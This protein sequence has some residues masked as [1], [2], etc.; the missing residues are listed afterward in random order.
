MMKKQNL[1]LLVA[2]FTISNGLLGLVEQGDRDIVRVCTYNI[3]RGAKEKEA[4]NLWENRKGLVFDMIH[5]I[6]P[7]IIGMQEV[8]KGQFDD[9]RTV[10]ADYGSFG[11]PRSSK[12]K[13]WWQKAVMKHP[14]AKDEHNPLFYN[15]NTIK[16]L[17]QGNF[18]INPRGLIMHAN[19]P[20]ICT[21]G[22]FEDINTGKKCYVYNTHLDNGKSSLIRKKQINKILKHV[23]KHAKNA[24][25]MIMGDFN[26]NFTGKG[27]KYFTQAKRLLADA[28]FVDSRGVAQKTEG[29]PKTRTG[30]N[31]DE[32][33]FID[34]IFVKPKNTVVKKHVVVASPV[35]VFPSDHR[36]VYVDILSQ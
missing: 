9:L 31:N 11:E 15:K 12:M 4:K 19:L 16:L 3:R 22:L 20:R 10:L 29:P 24:L 8:V 30:W 28:N 23:K 26:M 34:Y 33:K 2:L 27:G 1:C 35:G 5:T 13:S 21:W 18:G 32:L 6:N 7:D 14:D 36:P 17:K 25:V